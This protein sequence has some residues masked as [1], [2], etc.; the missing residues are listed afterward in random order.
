MTKR[1]L[2]ATPR[3]LDSKKIKDRCRSLGSANDIGLSFMNTLDSA[4]S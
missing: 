4:A 2:G 3:E 1:Y